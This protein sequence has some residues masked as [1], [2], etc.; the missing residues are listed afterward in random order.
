M[1]VKKDGK[2]LQL[3]HSLEPLNK[4]MIQHSGVLPFT[5]QVAEQFAGRACGGMLDLFV[6]Y[7]E[8]GIAPAS[9]DLMTF[10]TPYGTLHLVTL[11]MGWTNSVPIFHDDA[12]IFSSL[13]F[14]IIRFPMSM[15]SLS[16]VLLMSI[17]FLTVVT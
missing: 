14:L 16:K 15:M 13:R 5:E 10:Q 8:R 7:G 1:V 4:V 11:P 12:L 2:A 6:G 9:R 17:G 3:V